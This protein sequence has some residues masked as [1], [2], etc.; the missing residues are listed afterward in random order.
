MIFGSKLA[1]TLG[2]AASVSRLR[3]PQAW[4]SRL[5]QPQGWRLPV[6]VLTAVLVMGVLLIRVLA[7]GPASAS[8]SGNPGIQLHVSGNQLVNASGQRVVLHGADRSGTEFMCVHNAGIFDGPSTA[9]SISMMKA[10][11][12]N[13]VRVPLNEACWNGESYVTKAYQG[14]TYRAAVTDYVQRLNA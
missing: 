2:K 1:R 8:V 14:A 5:R 11:G 3:L 7:S 6:A 12:I 9:A 4:L 13:A 10:Q